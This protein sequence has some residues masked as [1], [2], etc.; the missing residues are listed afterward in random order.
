MLTWNTIEFFF[1]DSINNISNSTN[2]IITF[3]FY[4]LSV[5]CKI[6][7]SMILRE[8]GVREVLVSEIVAR[9]ALGFGD[10]ISSAFHQCRHKCRDSTSRRSHWGR[11]EQCWVWEEINKFSPVLYRI[12]TEPQTPNQHFLYPKLYKILWKH[13]L[14]FLLMSPLGGGRDKSKG[15]NGKEIIPSCNLCKAQDDW[16]MQVSTQVSHP[17][18][19]IAQTA[20]LWIPLPLT[21]FE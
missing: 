21:E 9:A 1:N 19:Q 17:V 7:T 16:I 20:K 15:P 2:L 5:F 8:S 10:V 13:I 6:Q 12:C 18:P 14:H 11:P 4:N 3:Y